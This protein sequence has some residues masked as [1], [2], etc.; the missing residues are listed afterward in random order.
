MKVRV[1]VIGTRTKDM[2]LKNCTKFES[3]SIS[4]MKDMSL[5]TSLH[6]NFNLKF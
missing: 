4:S 3:C 2:M 5:H 1:M 6:A